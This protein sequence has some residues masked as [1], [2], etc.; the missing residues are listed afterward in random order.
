VSIC[1]GSTVLG[2]CRS[3]EAVCRGCGSFA[4]DTLEIIRDTQLKGTD[5][6]SETVNFLLYQ[7]S[8][9]YNPSKDQMRTLLL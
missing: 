5:N 6:A 8:I 7:A 9:V 2:Q 1:T 4:G 3:S